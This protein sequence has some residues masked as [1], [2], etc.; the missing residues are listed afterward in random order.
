[1]SPLLPSCQGRIHAPRRELSQCPSQLATTQQSPL[2]PWPWLWVCPH[3]HGTA[4]NRL[5]LIVQDREPGEEGG[6]VVRELEM[7][8]GGELDFKER[9][10]LG[11]RSMTLLLLTDMCT[12]AEPLETNGFT[13]THT[14]TLTP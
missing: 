7:V 10:A 13:H 12:D 4:Q 5:L 3:S 8:G 1:M 2:A 6:V 14:V 9:K 11:K